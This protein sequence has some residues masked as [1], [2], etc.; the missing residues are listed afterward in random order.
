MKRRAFLQTLA[1]ATAAV[2]IRGPLASA[3]PFPP[4]LPRKKHL[5]V[6]W[7]NGGPSHLDLWDVKVGSP[8]QGPFQPIQTAVEGIRVSELMKET[9]KEFKDLSIIRT[10]DSRD[11][12]HQRGAYRLNHVFPPSTQRLKYPGIG[13]LVGHWFSLGTSRVPG[14]VT[15]GGETGFGD[16][17]WLGARAAGFPVLQPGVAPENVA[18]PALG[19]AATTSARLDLRRSLL[20]LLDDDFANG[21]TPY[22]KNA[23]ERQ[24]IRDAAQHVRELH[25]QAFHFSKTSADV[26]QFNDKDNARLQVRF[27]NTSFGRGCLL[28]AK[29]V[30]AGTS[31]VQ[32]VLGGWDLHGDP[33]QSLPPL[34]AQL[35]RGFAGLMAELRETGLIKDTVVL[36]AAAHGRKPRINAA[37]GRAPWSKGWSVVLGG[38]G[39]GGVDYG[40]T[41]KDGEQIVENP[42]SVELLYGTIFAA[43]GVPLPER[44]PGVK[45]QVEPIKALL[46]TV[47]Y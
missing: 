13:A 4:P 42:V 31:A 38:A 43:L 34:A 21:L 35:D 6:L 28:A 36:W 16:G 44:E 1:A 24:S 7:M 18:P 17:G 20:G 26:F 41:D 5:I 11:G 23:A 8:N 3:I 10:L 39:I 12:D 47:K 15:I 46:G 29:L 45:L 22:L 27:G 33:A 25:G 40:K 32:V 37:G 30:Q 9:A 14:C 19:D 2:P